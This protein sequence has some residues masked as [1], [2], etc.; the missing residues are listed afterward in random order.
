MFSSAFFDRDD[1]R[2]ILYAGIKK[3]DDN[4]ITKYTLSDESNALT[5]EALSCFYSL[6][7]LAERVTKRDLYLTEEERYDLAYDG[8]CRFLFHK[9]DNL[10]GVARYVTNTVKDYHRRKNSVRT[11]QEPFVD[12]EYEIVEGEQHTST[13]LGNWFL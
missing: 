3:Y 4:G 10:H 7:H 1:L 2:K 12:C 5:D 9:P 11:V 6:L 8:V 13:W